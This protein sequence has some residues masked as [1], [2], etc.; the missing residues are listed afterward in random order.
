MET[1]KLPRGKAESR[2]R[3]IRAAKLRNRYR[4]PWV[5]LTDVPGLDE[6]K[7]DVY[8][9][10]CSKCGQLRRITARGVEYYTPDSDSKQ[11]FLEQCPYSSTET[12]CPSQ[13][14]NLNTTDEELEVLKRFPIPTMFDRIKW[15]SDQSGEWSAPN[16][17]YWCLTPVEDKD[18]TEGIF[19]APPRKPEDQHDGDIFPCMNPVDDPFKCTCGW[20]FR[21]LARQLLVAGC[22]PEETSEK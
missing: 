1:I 17:L 14:E 11:E 8:L 2:A 21:E 12:P 10:W 16:Y 15:G 13:T 6:P 22:A 19:H 3:K 18:R 7:P 4:H 5:S 9:A 20:R